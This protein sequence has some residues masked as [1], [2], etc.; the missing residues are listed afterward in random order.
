[1]QEAASLAPFVVLLGPIILHV[2]ALVQDHALIVLH[3]QV[4][5]IDQDAQVQ[6]QG[7]ALTVSSA[8][9]DSICQDAV[10]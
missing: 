2:G 8:L 6:V 4:D 10:L 5:N 3:V 1:M 7:C 9:L